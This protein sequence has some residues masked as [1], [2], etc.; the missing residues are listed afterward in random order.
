MILYGLKGFT[1]GGGYLMT[2][3]SPQGVSAIL[4]A[5]VLDPAELRLEQT[6][7][8]PQVH[9]IVDGA[10]DRLIAARGITVL[11]FPAWQARKDELGAAIWR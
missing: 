11:E 1:H 8:L 4:E 3:M 9:E 5:L 7:G 2:L 10:L 6:G